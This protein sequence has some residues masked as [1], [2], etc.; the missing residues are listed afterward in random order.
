MEFYFFATVSQCLNIYFIFLR[1]LEVKK[2]FSNEKGFEKYYVNFCREIYRL[3]LMKRLAV[4][5]NRDP[6]EY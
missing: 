4:R 1:R 6:Q 3:D 5:R 2:Q